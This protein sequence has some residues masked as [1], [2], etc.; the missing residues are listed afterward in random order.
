M[1]G[2][3]PGAPVEVVPYDASWPSKFAAEAS[4]LEGLLAPWLAGAIE[5]IGSTAVPGLPAKPVIDIMAPVHSLQ[6]SR[7]AI[8]ALA[9][10]GAGYLHHPYK[11]QEM[12]WFCK[13]SPH[14]RT[15]HL[16]L[17]PL[18]SPLWHR[19]LRFRDALRQNPA[20]AA[21]YAE[22]KRALAQQ[23]RF[24]REAYTQA[25]A[26][27]IDRVLSGFETPGDKAG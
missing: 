2:D 13:P 22:L 27:F 10:A 19:Q 21:Q 9:A 18:A 7:P 1:A 6:A 20:L 8:Q 25:K 26:P 14:L 4:L 16:H 15:H 23:F 3:N 24:D 11:A 12:H 5:H 17:V